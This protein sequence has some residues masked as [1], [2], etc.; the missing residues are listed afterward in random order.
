MAVPVPNVYLAASKPVTKQRANDDRT[1]R[2]PPNHV[3]DIRDVALG[4]EES[5]A[6]V[7]C[8]YL[9]D[10]L[11]SAGSLDVDEEDGYVH[12]LH[13]IERFVER[14][15]DF[16]RIP[17][18]VTW[19]M[20]IARTRRAIALLRTRGNATHANVLM[21][22]YGHDDPFA[23]M[24][25][26]ILGRELANLARYT[27]A[28]E[29]RRIEMVRVETSRLAARPRTDTST[30]DVPAHWKGDLSKDEIR[31]DAGDDREQTGSERARCAMQMG[32]RADAGNAE[33]IDLARRRERFEWATLAISS[34]DAIRHALAAFHEPPCIPIP[35]EG[36]LAFEARKEARKDRQKAHDAKRETFMLDVKIDAYRMLCAAEK[37]YH[38][39]WLKSHASARVIIR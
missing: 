11:A 28:V 8:R 22:A 5:N 14:Y 21:V 33:V 4:V 26:G 13:E 10:Q 27:D 25:V 18:I 32:L 16:G 31:Y 15:G 38:D 29:L 17:Q 1:W 20:R 9:I 23:S 19:R 36:R 30:K 6:G 37:A 2:L 35:G 3:Q 7:C 34:G 24:L 12:R 39:A